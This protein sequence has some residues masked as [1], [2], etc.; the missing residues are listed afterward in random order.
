MRWVPLV[1]MG[2]C[3]VSN[4]R[5]PAVAQD[6]S[7]TRQAY[8]DLLIDEKSDLAAD[9]LRVIALKEPSERQFLVERLPDLIQQPAGRAWINAVRLTGDL[10]IVEAVPVLASLLKDPYSKGG[11]SGATSFGTAITLGDDPPGRAL[12]DIGEPALEAV[13]ALLQDPDKFVRWRAAL[14][15]GNMNSEH[16]DQALERNLPNETFE[17]IKGYTQ[18]VLKDHMVAK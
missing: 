15:L 1:V 6:L 8:Q 7:D 10:K 5:M 9:R 3:L 18:S 17:P 16:A 13:E 2:A 12:A 4:A 14:V 11:L